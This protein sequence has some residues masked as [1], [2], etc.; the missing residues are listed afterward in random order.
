MIISFKEKELKSV[1]KPIF[2]S[3]HI[4]EKITCEFVFPFVLTKLI[5]DRQIFFT[6]FETFEHFATWIG[7]T[8]RNCASLLR[9]GD[10]NMGGQ[11]PPWCTLLVSADYKTI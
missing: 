3:Q 11:I 7:P 9:F 6:S 10:W 1:T 8:T 4:Y 2:E 5:H